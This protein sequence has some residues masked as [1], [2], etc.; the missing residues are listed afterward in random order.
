MRTNFRIIKKN[1][2][3]DPE[4]GLN[5]LV[6]AFLEEKRDWHIG[7]S[8]LREPS[9]HPKTLAAKPTLLEEM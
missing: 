1:S 2:A 4:I 8:N 6:R 7:G 3:A 9:T 5:V